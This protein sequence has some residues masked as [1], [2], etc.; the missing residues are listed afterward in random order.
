MFASIVIASSGGFFHKVEQVSLPPIADNTVVAGENGSGDQY[1]GDSPEL[2]VGQ[3]V[4]ICSE[5]GDNGVT[6]SP[7]IKF[8]TKLGL[9]S[10]VMSI[11]QAT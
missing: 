5:S 4:K 6:H 1:L 2:E 9:S 3:I 8:R 7:R 10:A 11:I